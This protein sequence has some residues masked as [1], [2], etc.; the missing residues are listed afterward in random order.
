LRLELLKI[1]FEAKFEQRRETMSIGRDELRLELQ[2]ADAR[3][4]SIPQYQDPHTTHCRRLAQW[5]RVARMSQPASRLLA[6]MQA[7]DKWNRH[8]FAIA[9]R[10]DWAREA[11][12][13]GSGVKH[14]WTRHW[15]E[16]LAGR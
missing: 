16:N 3:S 14:V 11:K 13:N 10:L 1:P 6:M 15:H 2:M 5:L 8:H 12:I 4:R 7:A 9:P